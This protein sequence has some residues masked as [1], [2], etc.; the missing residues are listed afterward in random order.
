MEE[1]KYLKC[2]NRFH[3]DCRSISATGNVYELVKCP[4]CG[5]T[6]STHN[7]HKWCSGCYTLF[8]LKDGRAHFGKGL[9]KSLAVSFAIALEKSGGI[10]I[11]DKGQG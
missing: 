7:P 10:G 11:S 9:E 8:T 4:W 3:G 2:T 6:V 5:Y 1:K